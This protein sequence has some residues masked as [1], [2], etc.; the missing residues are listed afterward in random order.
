MSILFK[1]KYYFNGLSIWIMDNSHGDVYRFVE[2]V[3]EQPWSVQ[4]LQNL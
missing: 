2:L 4:I 3:E 1:S